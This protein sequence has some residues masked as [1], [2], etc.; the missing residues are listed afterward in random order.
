MDGLFFLIGIIIA[1]IAI[2]IVVI[3][4][5][6][7]I[8][9]SVRA[10][11]TSA[12]G[13]VVS[14]INSNSYASGTGGNSSFAMGVANSLNAN[15][16]AEEESPRSLSGC[17]AL[18]MPQILK[19][20]PDFDAIQAEN[21]IKDAIVKHLSG[22]SNVKIYN[23]VISKYNRAGMQKTIIYQASASY[24]KSGNTVQKRYDIQYAYRIQSKNGESI[25]ANCPNCGGVLTIGE[26]ECSFC[27][28]RVVNAMD[29]A[30]SVEQITES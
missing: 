19:D 9:K 4:I 13:Q 21:I 3:K 26:T 16:F 11:K 17:D 29:Q 30:W 1:I 23:I 2:V 5:R 7:A 10:F 6:N 8:R 18:L 14:A 15:T 20:F 22:K 25:A 28:S 27:G 12:V 24:K